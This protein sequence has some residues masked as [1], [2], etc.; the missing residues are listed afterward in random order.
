MPLR[1]PVSWIPKIDG[2]VRQIQKASPNGTQALVVRLHKGVQPG[3][4][5][6]LWDRRTS[7]FQNCLQEF[8]GGLLAKET[9]LVVIALTAIC[10]VV[11]DAEVAFR[12]ANPFASLL[13]H[14]G[15]FLASRSRCEKTLS[16]P[17]AIRGS[18]GSEPAGPLKK[19]P[20]SPSESSPID[21][22]DSGRA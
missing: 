17:I 16:R 11:G 8:F 14:R 5:V 2:V 4:I 10:R 12:F 22:V 18:W 7:F 9:D 6:G 15:L 19:A 1:R 20:V 13:F 3:K 21:R